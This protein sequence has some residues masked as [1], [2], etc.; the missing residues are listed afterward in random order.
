MK[1]IVSLLLVLLLLVTGC[2]AVRLD[3]ISID[4]NIDILLTDK[5]KVYNVSFDGYKYYVPLGLKFIEKEEYNA[6][7]ID[8]FDNRYYLYVDAISYFHGIDDNFKKTDDTYYFKE[9]NY[10]KKKGYI[11]ISKIGENYFVEYVF[12]YAKMEA[13][14][15]SDNLVSVVNNMSYVLRSIKYNDKILESIIGDDVLSYKEETF[16]LFDTDA[17][18]DDFLDVVSRYDPVSSE[19]KDQEE[20]DLNE[21]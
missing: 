8:K 7:F 4:K 15:K 2:S 19:A 21:D 16:S 17:S 10:N 11:Q 1:K 12:N 9:L 13:Y 20:L 6:I 5:V 3:D 18:Q 14:A